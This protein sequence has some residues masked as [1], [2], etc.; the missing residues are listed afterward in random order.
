MLN[1]CG[2]A[3]FKPWLSVPNVVLALAVIFTVSLLNLT[4]SEL[5]SWVQ[6]VGSIAAIWGAFSISNRQSKNQ[7]AQRIAEEVQKKRRLRGILIYLA[8]KHLVKTK[9]L[10]DAV[11]QEYFGSDTIGPYLEAKFHLEWPSHW[12][13][14]KAID[15]NGLEPLEVGVVIDMQVATQFALDVCNRLGKNWEPTGDREESDIERLMH[16]RK[17][18]KANFRYLLD[19]A[20]RCQSI[21]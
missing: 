6:S 11:Q 5:A 1:E 4:S 14:L 18:A 16:F 9:L 21:V 12:E 20:A 13:A 2:K 8:D 10:K 3:L 15:I 17:E 19:E 7:E